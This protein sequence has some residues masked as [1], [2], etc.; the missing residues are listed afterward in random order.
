[1][2]PDL[3][4]TKPARSGPPIGAPWWRF[5]MVWLVISGPAVVVVASFASMALAFIYADTELHE[6]P[7]A[8]ATGSAPAVA[9]RPVRPAALAT[10]P[11]ELARNHAATPPR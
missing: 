9:V 5:G 4:L 7:M 1:M 3:S 2:K 10:A 6:Q 11:A 8:I